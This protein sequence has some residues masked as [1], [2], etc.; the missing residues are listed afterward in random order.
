MK[1]PISLRQTLGLTFGTKKAR[2]A[3][4]SI[5]ENAI[6]PSKSSANPTAAASAVINAI[7][8]S[9]SL[10]PS[11]ADVQA[12]SHA[13][14]PRPTPN[15]DATTVKDVYTITEIVGE[16]VLREVKVKPWVEAVEAG[17]PV[18][19]S[20]RF[21]SRR[22]EDCVESDEI[23]KLKVLKYL[24]LLLR[25]YSALRPG[26]GK[27]GKKVP[28]REVLV[29]KLE[30][31]SGLCD[32]IRRRFAEGAELTKWHVDKLRAHCCALSLIVDD[33]ES[34][35]HDLREDLGLTTKEYVRLA[36]VSW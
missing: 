28:P 22:I 2:K 1:Q 32:T 26:R 31:D 16:S 9:A 24:L 23:Q 12:A 6:S 25:F 8:A 3:I 34:D 36:R 21:V 35:T 13:A 11:K 27:T 7:S 10:A 17:I 30:V 19:T 20:S 4:S 18:S 33:F 15:L 14:Q 5:A 29:E